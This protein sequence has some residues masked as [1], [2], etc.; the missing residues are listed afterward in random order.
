[1]DELAADHLPSAMGYDWT[2][3]TYQQILASKDVTDQARVPA[4]GDFSCCWCWQRN[5]KAGRCQLRS[6]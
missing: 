3:L 6:S 5:T 2:E 1:V 4:G